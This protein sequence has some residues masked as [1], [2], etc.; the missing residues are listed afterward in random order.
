MSE[1]TL[2]IAASELKV[3]NIVVDEFHFKKGEQFSESVYSNG[4]T[5]VEY[6]HDLEQWVGFVCLSIRTGMEE[7]AESKPLHQIQVFMHGIYSLR[8]KNTPEEKEAFHKLLRTTGAFNVL[9]AMR[10]IVLAATSALGLA[11]GYITP[12]WNLANYKWDPD[13]WENNS[14]QE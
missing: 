6:N 2:N 11:P 13:P 4:S 7:T 12:F 14:S 8:R 10:A 5:H 1:N 9:A 3:A